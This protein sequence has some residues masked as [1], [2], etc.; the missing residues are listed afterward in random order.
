MKSRTHLG[1]DQA[2]CG[3]V[4]VLEEG[5]ATAALAASERMAVDDR[6]LVH[7]G[8]IFGL[9]DYAAMLAVNDPNVVLG[10]AEVRFTAPVKVGDRVEAAA[11]VTETKG[12]KRV[13]EVNAAVGEREV[14]AGTFT[15]FVLAEHVLGAEG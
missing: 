9:A 5:R 13:V 2:L 10:A 4:V 6:G 15:A 8:F 14:F 1:I 12:K 3:E 11:C 7:G